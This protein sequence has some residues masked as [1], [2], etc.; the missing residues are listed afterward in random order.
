MQGIESFLNEA[1]SGQIDPYFFVSHASAE[2]DQIR[3]I[4]E[5]LLDAAIVAPHT[6]RA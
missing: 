1:R 2:N 6:A 4:I 5:T 3:P